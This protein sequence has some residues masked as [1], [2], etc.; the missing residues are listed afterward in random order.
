MA[1]LLHA[2]TTEEAQAQVVGGAGVFAAIDHEY[3]AC[4]ALID[5]FALRV[6][7]VFLR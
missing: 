1:V 4:R 2:V 5:G 7:T 3:R 6:S